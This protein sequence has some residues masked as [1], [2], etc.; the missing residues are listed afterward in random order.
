MI[1]IKQIL[2]TA[3]LI[4]SGMLIPFIGYSQ[5]SS[6]IQL[7]QNADT[8]TLNESMGT[9]IGVSNDTVHVVWNDKHNSTHATIYY[10]RSV[11]TGLTWSTPI[12]ITDSTIN[13]SWNPTI[14]VNGPNIHV[15]WREIGSGRASWYKHSLD[16]GNT[17]SQSMFLD[18]TADW[19][20]I[21]VSGSYVYIAN[22]RVVSQVPYNTEIFF[23]RSLD[24]GNTW[25]TPQ[26]LTF[27]VGRSEDEAINAQGSHIHMAWND[28]RE[29]KFQ[30][31]YK[32]SADYGATWDS[33]RVVI[34]T[35]DYNT[36]V[37]I[38]NNH[39]DVIATGAVTGHY[40][41]LLAQSA[42]TGA[43]WVPS[44]D[45]S[46]DTAHTYFLPDMVRDSC[47]LHVVVNSSAG[48]KYYH[49]ADG[50][51]NWDP[52]Y[53]MPGA[54]F[55]AYS[56]DVLHVVYVRTN[57]IYYVR[58]PTGNGGSYCSLISGISEPDKP[59]AVTVYP[60]PNNGLCS[61]S[62]L[63][64]NFYDLR[65]TDVTGREVYHQP[66]NIQQSS[67][68]NLTQLSKGVYF[69]QL[70]NKDETVRGRFVKD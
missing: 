9:C 66:I 56:G 36:M 55:I 69:Y 3:L 60:D 67:N 34:D 44:M 21:T 42:D 43:T 61:F 1:Q 31:L 11:D 20:A 62:N 8:T 18:S 51:V 22:D 7:S 4:S 52:P 38:N 48:P 64:F 37:S 47:K 46:N 33:D 29:G 54:S 12:P 65:I 16:G 13:N 35:S 41:L 39:V 63:R 27:A 15:A 70:S 50:G 23:M 68:I 53:S 10:S 19:P 58:N 59:A 40:Q 14:A 17:W 2:I 57:K 24:T 6:P 28:N 32:E 26:Q 49:S 30:I 5:W 25:S 45:I